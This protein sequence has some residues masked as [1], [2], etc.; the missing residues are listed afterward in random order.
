MAYLYDIL[1]F[2]KTSEEHFNHLQE[3]LDQLWKHRVKVET[4]EMS[5]PKREDKVLVFF[6]KMDRIKPNMDKLKIIRAMPKP[7]TSK[8]F[9]RSYRVPQEIHPSILKTSESSD[10]DQEVC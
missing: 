8:V 2:S 3:V 5:V 4:A 10:I 9:H 7:K 6:H 1:V